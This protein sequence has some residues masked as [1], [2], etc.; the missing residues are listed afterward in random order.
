[1]HQKN[2][3]K[4]LDLGLIC[5][6]LPQKCQKT[7]IFCN[8]K[9]SSRSY[10]IKIKFIDTFYLFFQFFMQCAVILCHSRGCF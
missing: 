4:S 5:L 6:K 2:F 7:A 9:M 10:L 1:M 8:S 3:Q